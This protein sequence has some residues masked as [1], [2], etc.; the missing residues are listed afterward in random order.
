[1]PDD[2]RLNNVDKNNADMRRHDAA[3]LS[4]I[5]RALLSGSSLSAVS[6]S[7]SYPLASRVAPSLS[8][9]FW[10]LVL[11]LAACGGGGGGGGGGPA[12]SGTPSTPAAPAAPAAPAMVQKSGFVHNKP[13]SGGVAWL[14]VNNNQ[15]ID[16]DD[17]RIPG[18]TNE[19]GRYSGQVPAEHQNKAVMVDTRNTK[20]AGQLPDTLLSVPNANIVSPITHGLARKSIN[21]EDL[22][23]QYNPLQQNIYEETNDPIRKA[24]RKA[25]EKILPRISSQI[26]QNEDNIA[27]NQNDIQQNAQEIDRLRAELKAAL[28]A[29][30]QEVARQVEAIEYDPVVAVTNNA[31]LDEGTLAGDTN[32]GVSFSVTD[33]DSGESGYRTPR[34][35]IS[36]DNRFKLTGDLAS[37]YQIVANARATFTSGETI[38]LRITVI[39]GNT[40]NRITKD[41]SFTVGDIEYPPT[42]TVS[43]AR[44]QA[45]LN[46]TIG[47]ARTPS[48]INLNI[49]VRADDADGNLQ[50]IVIERQVGNRFVRDTRFEVKNNKLYVKAG[51]QFDY[52][53]ADNPNGVITLRITAS[54]PTRSVS[55]TVTVHITNQNDPTTGT[56]SVSGLTNGNVEIGGEGVTAQTDGLTDP[57]DSSLDFD[58]KWQKR[59][60]DGQWQYVPNATSANFTPS[61]EGTYRLEV[62]AVDDDVF[63]ATSAPFYSATFTVT[64][65]PQDRPT[66]GT[67]SVSN[68]ARSN[69]AGSNVETGTA[70]TA[71]TDG[72]TDPDDDEL[73]F[74]YKWQK[75]VNGQWQYVPNETSV[76]FTPS[77]EGTYRLEVTARDSVFNATSAPFHSDP[78]TV[79]T[80]PQDRPTT[81][82]VSVSSS[83]LAGS[84]VDTGTAVT[85]VTNLTDPDDSSLDFDYKWQK[86]QA[87]GQWQ[88]VPNATSA[89]FTP[90]EAGTYRLEVTARDSVFNATSAPFYSATF[91]VTTPPQDRPTT[92]TVSVSGLTNG[93]VEI[94]GEG[95][96]AQ[97]DGLT[98]PDDSSLDFD[99]KWQKQQVNGQWQY[100]P[101][102]T[103]AN[104][105]PSEAGTYR[106]EVT[107]RDS[108]FSAT[109]APFHSD[110]FTVTTPPLQVPTLNTIANPRPIV[111]TSETDNF[112]DVTGTF[113]SPDSG[114]KT[115]SVANEV[116]LTGAERTSNPTFTHKV[117]MPLATLWFHETSGAYKITYDAAA[118]NSA[119]PTD[120]N[121][122]F[123]VTVTVAGQTSTPKTLQVQITAVNDLPDA[124]DDSNAVNEG[125][126]I[127]GNVISNDSDAETARSALRITHI[128]TGNGTGGTAGTIGNSLQGQYGTLTLNDKG[129]YSYQAN[130]DIDF[131]RLIPLVY[132]HFTYRVS[133]GTGGTATA[134]LSIEVN[135]APTQ[136]QPQPQEA[137]EIAFTAH[138]TLMA[139]TVQ[140]GTDTGIRFTVSG[141]ASPFNITSDYRYTFAVQHIEGN[142][143]KV[144]TSQTNAFSDGDTIRL[145]VRVTRSS[146][147]T[148]I[149]KNLTF[150]VGD[151]RD[152]SVD[153]GPQTLLGQASIA[154]T[155]KVDNY[156]SPKTGADKIVGFEIRH[157][158]IRIGDPARDTRFNSAVPEHYNI[159]VRVEGNDTLIYNS[160]ENALAGGGRQGVFAILQGVQL[161]AENLKPGA[162]YAFTEG[163]VTPTFVHDGVTNA[164]RDTLTGTDGV[165][166]TYIIDATPGTLEQAD[167]ITG[168]KR[169][170][171]ESGFN[172]YEKIIFRS[173]DGSALPADTIISY[174]YDGRAHKVTVYLGAHV[175][176]NNI[177]LVFDNIFGDD[178]RHKNIFAP[179]PN[180]TFQEATRTNALDNIDQPTALTDPPNGEGSFDDVTGIFTSTVAG[181]KIFS[182]YASANNQV[183]RYPEAVTDLEFTHKVTMPL[184]TL[185][186][187]ETSGAYKITYD[188]AAINSAAPTDYNYY[189]IVT[190][191]VAGQTSTPKTLQVQITA[192]NDLPDA[193]DDS[194]AVNEGTSISGN[195]ISNDSDAETARSAL[196]ITHIWTGDGTATT[197]L[198][199]NADGQFIVRTVHGTLTLNND[200]SYGYVA[201]TVS[202]T[203]TD[204]FTYRVID[205]DGGTNTATLTITVN[206]V[207]EE[208]SSSLQA[209]PNNHR[210]DEGVVS[211]AKRLAI[212]EL[213][214]SSNRSVEILSVDG[215]RYLDYPVL[216]SLFEIRNG[217]ELWLKKD[218]ELE[219]DRLRP[220]PQSQG[221]DSTV[222]DSY[223]IVLR[224]QINDESS[225]DITFTLNVD[226]VLE[227]PVININGNQLVLPTTT[228]AAQNFY[229]GIRLEIYDP[230]NIRSIH[231]NIEKFG[232][233]VELSDDRF[234]IAPFSINRPTGFNFNGEPPKQSY[235]LFLKQGN[236]ITSYDPITL[237]IKATDKSDTVIQ[238]EIEFQVAKVKSSV[239]G[240]EVT[241]FTLV[242]FTAG[243]RMTNSDLTVTAVII[244][245]LPTNNARLL[246]NN[247]DVTKGQV[248]AIN[249][250]PSLTYQ[251]TA[252]YDFGFKFRYND[253]YNDSLLSAEYTMRINVVVEQSTPDIGDPPVGQEMPVGQEILSVFGVE[254]NRAY[255]G[256]TLT[257]PLK[258]AGSSTNPTQRTYGWEQKVNNVWQDVPNA[259]SVRFTPTEAGT[260]RL[261]V[262]ETASGSS[263]RYF[264]GEFTVDTA[265]QSDLT[266]GFSDP[267]ATQKEIQETHGNASGKGTGFYLT[268]SVSNLFTALRGTEYVGYV[269][270]IESRQADGSFAIDTRFSVRSNGKL[271]VKANKSLDF[272]SEHNPNGLIELRI[273]VRD[274]EGNTAKLH[275]PIQLTDVANEIPFG[276][277][278]LMTG[279]GRSS[280]PVD[281]D[282]LLPSGVEYSINEE[283]FKDPEGVELTFT[284]KWMTWSRDPRGTVTLGTPVT[285][286]SFTPPRA[287]SYKL[288]L[289]VSDGTNVL[290]MEKVFFFYRDDDIILDNT[291]VVLGENMT[292]STAAVATITPSFAP[293]FFLYKIND[294]LVSDLIRD[295]SEIKFEVRNQ[296]ELWVKPDATFDFEKHV[297][298]EEGS[299]RPSQA[300]IKVVLR[301]S[302][303]MNPSADKIFYLNVNDV[304][305]NPIVTL[306]QND[307]ATFNFTPGS[308]EYLKNIAIYDPDDLKGEGEPTDLRYELS[309]DTRFELVKYEPSYLNKIVP[310]HLEGVHYR[311]KVKSDAQLNPGET[312]TLIITVYEGEGT[313]INGQLTLTINISAASGQSTSGQSGGS[314]RAM[315]EVVQP[316]D[317]F[318]PDAGTEEIGTVQNDF[319]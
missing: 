14:D 100:V 245:R 319:L 240:N 201:R 256:E 146:D 45:A 131:A 19:Q 88:Y 114:T 192:V 208:P 178:F 113:T 169:Q 274:R 106:L 184:A 25:V 301:D 312:I 234:G 56:V 290:R 191:T 65:P 297:T 281:T 42:L 138:S 272:E 238:E 136:P 265:L 80:P 207:P 179:Q 172:T 20:Y 221:D 11:M 55:K 237:I 232:V 270:T 134:R 252:S 307:S 264:S 262:T 133:D 284:Y 16:E 294:D 2:Y 220:Q 314:G 124:N 166:E 140:H 48:E 38:D 126:S 215:L 280:V 173:A 85:A 83:N 12:T 148:R 82:T 51:Q 175:G 129:A 227:D 310:G 222:A 269:M 99:Y 8:P 61:E 91:T 70:V 112:A 263:S 187:H 246:L 225:T 39:D 176:S 17:Y 293:A 9:G 125:T 188:A 132:D 199:P 209:N 309:D 64:T 137:V 75:Q 158:K 77:E 151:P 101:N 141:G 214:I 160:L 229:T 60:A 6:A 93:N 299:T 54:D 190:V 311:L 15:R 110:P 147:N 68:L 177:L 122:Y 143:Y 213:P 44:P 84:N 35:A 306:R 149:E 239:Q 303:A 287:G 144:V 266:L 121:Y 211:E 302:S 267:D 244:S 28:T 180:V 87:D 118:I 95:V 268:S 63:N 226:N 206:D 98:D 104:F 26:K 117:T 224:H 58:Y 296:H 210:M 150:V 291:A 212:I 128:W 97:T 4:V 168:F 47:N 111:D 279:T 316:D 182:I 156:V 181:N 205:G 288:E 257:A 157:D 57:D 23:E 43:Q 105:T 10:P 200:G 142:L 198:L 76:R 259:T 313:A 258:S 27:R 115:Y 171:H 216:Q 50:P 243:T 231:D 304:P 94:G 285:S 167:I 193:N 283:N 1:M 123:I 116:R 107:A 34:V 145:T 162:N 194:N 40:S 195:V 164:G 7:T 185:W 3:S 298:Y 217:N 174:E 29:L 109:S 242:D 74:D 275:V 69:V 153:T 86:R 163:R 32:I 130:D 255:T 78:F 271:S 139:G 278:E 305:E 196:R 218:A 154:D 49:D 161:T 203:V 233:K 18:Q 197:G 183:D 260:Y 30:K 96:T 315:T 37:G 102:A 108:V 295:R 289:D 261:R 71:Q 81:G 249:D 119:A 223:E 186:F 24:V 318:V 251:P 59:Q 89:N 13:F 273:T 72:L 46:E 22:P 127:S 236:T 250:L 286:T 21:R 292:Y 73:D 230:D 235:S 62:T 41:V 92:G 90:S 66:T 103:S 276:S 202:S 155:F 248:I 52:E 5:S 36:G 152:G 241:S 79:T 254:N 53:H 308:R 300:V 189:F 247:S 317:D 120:Y 159:W 31:N 219:Y 277:L 204:V 228:E 67:V 165:R 253:Y 33:A 170:G 135:D 282:L